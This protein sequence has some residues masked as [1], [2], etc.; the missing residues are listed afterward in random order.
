MDSSELLAV[1]DPKP[2]W[3]SQGMLGSLAAVIVGVLGLSRW[4]IDPGTLTDLLLAIGGIVSG[5]LAA[6]GR[7]K[8]QAP[9]AQGLLPRRRLPP[10]PD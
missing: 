5:V 3:R 1:S 6:R 9:I 10:D 7:A 4:G 2:W 8:A